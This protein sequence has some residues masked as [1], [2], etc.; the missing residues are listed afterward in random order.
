MIKCETFNGDHPDTRFRISDYKKWYQMIDIVVYSISYTAVDWKAQRDMVSVGLNLVNFVTFSVRDDQ[1]NRYLAIHRSKAFGTLKKDFQENKS[2]YEAMFEIIIS[3]YKTLEASSQ[4][5]LSYS[6]RGKADNLYPL[7]FGGMFEE[8]FGFIHLP[9][10]KQFVKFVHDADSGLKRMRIQ[11]GTLSVRFYCTRVLMLKNLVCQ[12]DEPRPASEDRKVIPVS[13]K[14]L[15]DADIL[16][17]TMSC[18]A[19]KGINF[20]D[21]LTIRNAVELMIRKIVFDNIIKCQ[22]VPFT[23]RS[24]NV[25]CMVVLDTVR[26]NGSGGLEISFICSFHNPTRSNASGNFDRIKMLISNVFVGDAWNMTFLAL[27]TGYSVPDESSATHERVRSCIDLVLGILTG[28][29]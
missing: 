26:T 18:L 4:I 19:K 23:D 21:S 12:V 27:T 3:D 16:S 14:Q 6:Y 11:T 10:K 25:V 1:E 24:N 7:F 13:V 8:K 28:I 15:S 29:V 2:A 5:A 9:D 17:Q 22:T 20:S